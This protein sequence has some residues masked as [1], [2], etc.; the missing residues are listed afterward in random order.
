MPSRFCDVDPPRPSAAHSRRSGADPIKLQRQIAQFGAS[1]AGIIPLVEYEGSDGILVVYDGVTGV[2]D[3]QL[4]AVLY[5]HR[6]E[7][8]GREHRSPSNPLQPTG[9]G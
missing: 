2:D 3:E 7:L 8:A 1:S 4:L 9:N 6:A 5:Q